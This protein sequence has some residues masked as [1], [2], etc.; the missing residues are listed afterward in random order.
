MTWL[1]IAG[2]FLAAVGW[3][4]WLAQRSAI[5]ANFSLILALTIALGSGVLSQIMLWLGLLRLPITF[6][7]TTTI[8]LVVMLPGFA[9]AVRDGALHLPRPMPL[10]PLA[11]FGLAITAAVSA[12]VLINAALWPF[13]HDD[14]LGIYGRFAAWIRVYHQLYA[15]APG[16]DVYELYPQLVTL[17][18]AY[19][20]MVED[21]RHEYAAAVMGAL[22]GL[23]ALPATYLLGRQVYSERVGWV[24]AILLAATFDFGRWASAGYVDIPTAFFMALGAAFAY[25]GV[26]QGNPWDIFL[27]ALMMGFAAW[28]KNAALL[29]V[30]V[31]F[32]FLVYNLIL[33]QL[34][35]KHSLLAFG[36]VAVIDSPWYLRNLLIAGSLTPDTVWIEDARQT[37]REIFV[38]VTLPQN[39]GLVGLVALGGVCWGIGQ[40]L[41]GN[42][43][44]KALFLL[45]WALPFYLSW[46]LFA[47]YDPRFILLILPFVVVLGAALV[48]V[49][50]RITAK[51]RW[52]VTVAAVVIG[53]QAAFVVWYSVEYKRELLTQPVMTHSEKV[54]LVRP[55]S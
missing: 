37:W 1:M 39:Y 30:A 29:A 38:L 5:D 18:F 2:V 16:S 20:Y 33:N 54:N 10:S 17:N 9:L 11:T 35:L 47:S 32:T 27:A 46:L 12:A 13:H 28:T 41:W 8:Y 4:A 43:R 40:I 24:A 25:A 23:G 14:A 31:F 36:I 6:G 15:I 34:S 19:V 53:V 7:M 52:V 48:D 44:E 26:Q 45:I 50:A 55:D 49:A 42:G 21:W 51:R 3:S 22:I